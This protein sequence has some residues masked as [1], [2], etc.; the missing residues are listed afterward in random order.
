V[1][2][3][4]TITLILVI[5]FGLAGLALQAIV[6]AVGEYIALFIC[7]PPPIGFYIYQYVK[8]EKPPAQ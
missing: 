4:E 2:R 1:K 7:I 8:N 5:I 3:Y 6:G